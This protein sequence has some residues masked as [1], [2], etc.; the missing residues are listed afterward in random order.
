[1][2]RYVSMIV[3]KNNDNVRN[4]NAILEALKASEF[5]LSEE[6]N[7]EEV[8]QPKDDSI[9]IAFFGDYILIC[10]DFRFTD[11]FFSDVLCDEEEALINIFPNSDILSICSM[12]NLDF[13]GYA[14][15]KKGQKSHYKTSDVMDFYEAVKGNITKEELM[16]FENTDFQFASKM[17]HQ[18]L[19]LDLEAPTHEA[20]FKDYLFKKYIPTQLVDD[21]EEDLEDEDESEDV[22]PNA[23]SDSE[24]TWWQFW[25]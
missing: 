6:A 2:G 9:N 10:D 24:K 20:L 8:F 25:K 18:T 14:L 11:L 3:I 5:Q 12:G 1:M 4:D 16:I 23:Q 13:K 19:G 7:L 17:I 15:I 21:D 22:Q